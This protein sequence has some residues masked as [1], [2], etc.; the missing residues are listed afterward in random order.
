M[1]PH[2][3]SGRDERSWQGRATYAIL[4][5]PRGAEQQPVSPTSPRLLNVKTVE[6]VDRKPRAESTSQTV[7]LF[8]TQEGIAT[9]VKN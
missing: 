9:V 7:A 3:A 8:N 6:A 5:F 1:E 2:R 4:V